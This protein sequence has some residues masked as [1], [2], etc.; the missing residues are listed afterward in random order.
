M[1]VRMTRR[2]LAALLGA[3]V[4]APSALAQTGELLTR[5]IPSSGERLPAVGLGTSNVF[6]SGA[7]A[8]QKASAVLQALL[9]GGGRLIDTASTYGEAEAVLGD[10]MAAGSLRDRIFI[11]TKL[12]GARRGGAK[13]LAEPAQNR[14]ARPAPAPQCP[15][16]SAVTRAVQGLEG[17]GHLPLHRHHVDP[18]P[19]LS[20]G[21][22]SARAREAGFRADRLFPRQ[23]RGGEPYPAARGR[24]SGPA[25]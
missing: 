14:Q 23:P 9:A 18:P 10:V 12:E 11:A 22:G 3:A 6:G 24:R 7:E 13:A 16:Y 15:R 2:E 1:T 5:A 25:C 8:R 21:R 20:R 17:G 19:R 4:V